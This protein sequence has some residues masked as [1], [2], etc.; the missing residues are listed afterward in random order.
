MVPSWSHGFYGPT[1]LC[2]NSCVK[3]RRTLISTYNIHLMKGF[4]NLSTQLTTKIKHA[5][6]H[7]PVTHSPKNKKMDP[8]G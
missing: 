4:Q 7:M 2:Q 1:I 5:T 8:Q 3:V 6:F